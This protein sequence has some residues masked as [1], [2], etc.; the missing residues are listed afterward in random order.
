MWAKMIKQLDEWTAEIDGPEA[1]AHETPEHAEPRHQVQLGA[2]RIDHREGPD[3]LEAIKAATD[4]SWEHIATQTGNISK[5]LSLFC[6]YVQGSKVV[7]P[8]TISP[9]HRGHPLPTQVLFEHELNGSAGLN[10]LDRHMVEDL[11]R[12]GTTWIKLAV[13]AIALVTLLVIIL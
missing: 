5:A 13:V 6:A 10:G 1:R 12:V 4:D 3:K 2:L 8:S 11:D 7:K 9:E